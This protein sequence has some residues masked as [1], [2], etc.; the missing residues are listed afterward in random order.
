LNNQISRYNVPVFW[1]DEFKRLNYVNEPFNDILAQ[2]RWL[3][4]GYADRFTGDMCD[5]RSPQPTW[6]H[7]FIELFSALGWKD[8]G[9][10]YYRMNTGTVLP[11]HGDLYVKYIDLFDLDGQQHR[12]RRAIVFLE[13]WQPGH[14]AEYMGS[15]MVSWTAGTV[16]EWPYD[17][18]HMAANLGLEPRYTLQITGWI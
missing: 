11:V 10:S 12:I 18:P 7:R 2:Q 6:N 8:I 5:M 4:A 1:D 13:D 17:T 16:I 9:T 3:A 15:P 14:Y